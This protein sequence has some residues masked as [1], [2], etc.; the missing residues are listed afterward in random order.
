MK[1]PGTL[2]LLNFA[3]HQPETFLPVWTR[4]QPFFCAKLPE[5]K[6]VPLLRKNVRKSRSGRRE[7]FRSKI[8]KI[9]VILTIFRLFEDFARWR[10]SSRNK[11]SADLEELWIFERYH[12]IRL[13]KLPQISKKS[14]L[15]DFLGRGSKVVL[16]GFEGWV[17]Q[18]IVVQGP[19]ATWTIDILIPGG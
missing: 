3:S 7:R 12:E 13:E 19:F 6:S 11:W 8:V 2:I 18:A 10:R 15:Y 9:W 4:C 1:N 5:M 17:H 14:A 16:L